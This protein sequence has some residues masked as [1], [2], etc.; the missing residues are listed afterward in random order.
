MAE[1]RRDAVRIA[2]PATSANLGPGFD[3]LGLAIGL[4]DELVAMISDDPGVVVEIEGEGASYLRTDG[5]HLVART[6][7]RIFSRAGVEPAGF[8]LRCTNRIPH[9]RGLG[10]SSA[11]IVGG[12]FLARALIVDGEKI[13]D[14]EE[15]LDIATELEGHPD[16]AAAT[17]YGG[18]TI[19]IMESDTHAKV[20]SLRTHPD[21]RAIALVPPQPCSTKLARSL[22]PATVPHSDAA[23]NAGRTALLVHAMTADPSLLLHATADRLHQDARRSCY[24]AT[25]A[26]V[27]ALRARGIAAAVSGAGPTVLALPLPHQVEE[28]LSLKPNDW[29]LFDAGVDNAGTR[30]LR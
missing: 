3:S 4:H 11:A 29:A 24:P 13:I 9:S 14:D 2:V 1:L 27:E 19:A 20:V 15:L 16:N 28:V 18:F 10:S 21:V 22:L 17:L 26:L 25:L 7:R 6:M 8:V 12:L 23:F 5:D 30:V